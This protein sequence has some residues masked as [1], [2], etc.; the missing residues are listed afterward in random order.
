MAVGK[1]PHPVGCGHQALH[2]PRER[3]GL[4]RPRRGLRRVAPPR[5]DLVLAK[6]RDRQAG[7]D[8][9]AED[10]GQRM[11]P[12]PRRL[13]RHDGRVAR[14]GRRLDELQR[15]V[16]RRLEIERR[17]QPAGVLL[18]HDEAGMSIG[19][20]KFAARRQHGRNDPRPN[21]HVRQPA[22][23]SPSRKDEIERARRQMRGLVHGPLNEVGLQPGLVGKAAREIERRTG[24]IEPG[25]Q[26]RRV[27]PGRA[28]RARYGIA[29]GGRAFRK[30]RR[31]RPL[32]SRGACLRPRE[33]GRACS[34]RRPGAR[35]LSARSSQL[36]RLMS[37]GSS[38][39]SR[40]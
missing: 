29:G 9:R 30:R 18:Q 3:D 8:E 21:P 38:M 2:I 1:A 37:I 33:S 32:R 40:H 15:P 36:R 17:H 5:Q 28:C 35:E 10:R 39:P 12:H 34:R 24:E 13:M 26:R 14:V 27:A 19:A 16:G 11:Y 7:I 22:K 23:R 4:A 6:H 31:V 25:D 20:V